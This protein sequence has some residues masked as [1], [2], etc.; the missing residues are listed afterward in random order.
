MLK[1]L[2]ADK[3]K[4]TLQLTNLNHLF[5][6]CK[7]GAVTEYGAIEETMAAGALETITDWI[8]KRTRV[9]GQSPSRK[10]RR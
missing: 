9:N 6:T 8:L 5:Q 2:P 10:G 7:T 1:A 4:G 3:L